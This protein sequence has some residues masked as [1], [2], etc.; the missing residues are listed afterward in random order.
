MNTQPRN[1]KSEP[2][3][4]RLMEVVK[5][6]GAVL[7]VALTLFGI[8]SGISGQPLIAL[9]VALV[10]AILVSVWVVYTGWTGLLEV[11]VAWLVLIVIVLAGFVVWP[12]TMTVE[13]TVCDT[14]GTL[15]S[16]ESVALVDLYGVRRETLTDTEGRYQ[17]GGVPYGTYTVIARG[18]QVGGGAGG[19]LVRVMRT[20]LTVSESTPT[21]VPTATPTHTLTPTLTPTATP[22]HT[23]TPTPTSTATPT[24]TSTPTPTSTATPAHTPTPTST[25]T[26]TPTSTPTLTSTPAPG[27]ATETP[28]ADIV[29][30]EVYRTNNGDGGIDTISI[31]PIEQPLTVARIRIDMTQRA[32]DYGYSL[33]E[34]EAYGPPS[35]DINLI[36]GG[37]C[38]ASSA[39]NSFGCVECFADRAIDGDMQTRW[40]SDWSDPQWLEITLP[41]L[42]VINRIVLK[43]ENA[44]AEE[45]CVTVAVRV[46]R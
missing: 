15:I 6:L 8:I 16:H 4:N 34:V 7:G 3:P 12:R 14:A 21:L 20:D 29:D 43:W 40:S 26:F 33:W 36:A 24:H 17:F 30:V 37:R 19:I 22:T 18:H 5:A 2:S 11:V 25:P 23:P 32:T 13:G 44:Y 39:Q 27:V 31:E 28:V 35:G 46:I 41:G 42:Q 38:D 45:Y 9:V 10:V 1:R